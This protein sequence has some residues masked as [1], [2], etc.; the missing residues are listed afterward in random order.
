M[1]DFTSTDTYRLAAAYAK[2]CEEAQ[3]ALATK[4][5]ADQ[6][7]AKA[8]RVMNEAATAMDPRA[9]VLWHPSVA[10]YTMEPTP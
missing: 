6:Q 3:S 2:A 8:I 9:A 5:Y 7:L 4:V 1:T 10:T